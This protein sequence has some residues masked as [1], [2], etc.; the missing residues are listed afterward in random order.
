[1]YLRHTWA[2]GSSLPTHQTISKATIKALQKLQNIKKINNFIDQLEEI[3]LSSSNS[4]TQNQPKF[5][6]IKSKT[7]SE[8]EEDLDRL[9][10]DTKQ[11]TTMDGK[12]LSSGYIHF[13]KLSLRKKK[14]QKLASRKLLAKRSIHRTFFRTSM[15]RSNTAFS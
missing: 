9:L 1:M 2:P 12:A 4:E 10:E 11:E 3:G 14:N 5:G 15:K 13:T 7:L 6:A 8:L